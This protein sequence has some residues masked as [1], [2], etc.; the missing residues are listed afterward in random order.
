VDELHY[1]G[2]MAPLLEAEA[3]CAVLASDTKRFLIEGVTLTWS[4]G[5][6]TSG[7]AIF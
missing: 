5:P 1:Q 7:N 3:A 4:P 6:G 2:V